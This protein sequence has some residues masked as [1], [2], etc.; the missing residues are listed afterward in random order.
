MPKKD[1]KELVKEGFL[2]S[3]TNE[4]VKVEEDKG[5]A[6]LGLSGYA[7]D[8]LKSISGLEI[9]EVGESVKQDEICGQLHASKGLEDLYSPISGKII[10][11]N[12]ENGWDT[13]DEEG[14]VKP[15]YKFYEGDFSEM[16]K[17]PYENWILKVKIDPKK[18]EEE[19]K[20]L[21]TP[22]EYLQFISK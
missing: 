22:E 9:K 12:S 16:F 14:E 21:M 13:W 6:Y 17:Q 2:Y 3:N 10:E 1:L 7:T 5:I 19:K 11:I 8:Q 18:W 4:Y 15:G 20:N